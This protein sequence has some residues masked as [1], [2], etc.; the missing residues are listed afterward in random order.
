MFPLELA[1][2][3]IPGFK[4]ESLLT[5]KSTSQNPCFKQAFLLVDLAVSIDSGL[6]IRLGA[7]SL[8]ILS[9]QFPYDGNGGRPSIIEKQLE[10]IFKC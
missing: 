7:I 9:L 5:A 10:V 3:K 2:S 6:L 4:Q 8:L 1:V